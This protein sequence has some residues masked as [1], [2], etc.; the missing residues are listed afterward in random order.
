M[1]NSVKTF[2]LL[3]ICIVTVCFVGCSHNKKAKLAILFDRVDHLK[4]GSEVYYKGLPVGEVTY[5]DLFRDSVLV[6][7]KFTSAV[8]IPANSKFIINSSLIGIANISIEPSAKTT[9]L[10]SMDTVTGSY[11]E[12]GL[13]DN[14]VS[15]S[16][17]RQKIQES[18]DKVGEEIKKLIEAS[19]DTTNENK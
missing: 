8:K 10:T 15:D 7:I 11:R 13:L 2:L 6:E 16:A 14:L 5:L 19:R 9:F 17:K 18:I 12:K 1:G 4:E 3:I